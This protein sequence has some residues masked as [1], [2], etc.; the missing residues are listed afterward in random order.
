MSPGVSPVLGFAMGVLYLDET[1]LSRENYAKA[2]RIIRKN[3]MAGGEAFWKGIWRGWG[4]DAITLM[5]N[6]FRKIVFKEVILK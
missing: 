1:P 5:Q 6:L 2:K 4:N 3:E